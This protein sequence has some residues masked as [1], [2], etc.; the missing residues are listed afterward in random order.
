MKLPP[1]FT[2][3]VSC[4][5]LLDLV[6]CTKSFV[7][8]GARGEAGVAAPQLQGQHGVRL[9]ELSSSPRGQAGLLILG[10]K[11]RD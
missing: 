2:F 1:F 7:C 6:S 5:V 8:L 9:R 3:S 10:Q 4:E 11:V